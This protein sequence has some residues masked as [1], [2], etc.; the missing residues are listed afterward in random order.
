MFKITY[1][2]KEYQWLIKPYSLLH[3]KYWGGEPIHYFSPEQV[4]EM[5]C[6]VIYHKMEYNPGNWELDYLSGLR[7]MLN[8][9][10]EEIVFISVIDHFITGTVGKGD[11]EILEEYMLQ[12]KNI[13]KMNLVNHPFS[14]TDKDIETVGDMTVKTCNPYNDLHGTG[15]LMGGVYML[16]SLWNKGN[17][18]S[19]IEGESMKMTDFEHPLSKKMVTK[20]NMIGCWVNKL[21]FPAIWVMG[22]DRPEEINLVWKIPTNKKEIDHNTSEMYLFREDV[23]LIKANIPPRINVM[24]TMA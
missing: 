3:N 22:R 4:M 24:E 9:S 23:E 11:V 14:N 15:G 10:T 21:M 8:S 17:L 16:P 5:P 2:S 12:H 13:L 18:L 7:F 20:T 19:L 6:G 1:S